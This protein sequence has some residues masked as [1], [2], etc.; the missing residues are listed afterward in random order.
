MSTG[1]E[2]SIAGGEVKNIAVSS[3]CTFPY[4]YPTETKFG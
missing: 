1:K 2:I 3:G 4:D